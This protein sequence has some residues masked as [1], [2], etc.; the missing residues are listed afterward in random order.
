VDAPGGPIRFTIAAVEDA[1]DP[2][3]EG[4]MIASG[5]GTPARGLE[6]YYAW[7]SPRRIA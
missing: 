2:D 5:S 7:I 3:A 4:E 6:R 1:V